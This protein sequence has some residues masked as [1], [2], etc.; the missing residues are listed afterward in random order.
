VWQHQLTGLVVVWYMTGTTFNSAAVVTAVGDANWRIRG[1]GDFN[2]DGHADF[3]WHHAQS[4]Q[5]V[6]WFMNGAT[7]RD[8]AVVDQGSD[9][10]WRIAGVR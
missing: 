4:G 3:V 1:V 5:I 7:Y 9:P 10:S 6:M 2:R 8:Y